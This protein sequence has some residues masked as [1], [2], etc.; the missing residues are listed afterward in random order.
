MRSPLMRP[1]LMR[2]SIPVATARSTEPA[3][4]PFVSLTRPTARLGATEGAHR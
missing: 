1:P 3:M 2:A 4:S